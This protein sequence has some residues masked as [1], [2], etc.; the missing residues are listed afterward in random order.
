MSD[1]Q[2]LE[3]KQEH[4]SRILS[5]LQDPGKFLITKSEVI[6]LILREEN[7]FF[8]KLMREGNG[9]FHFFHGQY[10]YCFR[11]LEDALAYCLK[12]RQRMMERPLI[13]VYNSV[14]PLEYLCLVR[15][16][17]ER[18]ILSPEILPRQLLRI[19]QFH[20]GLF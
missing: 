9:R 8:V 17:K 18:M 4:R 12:E 20:N 14:P 2:Y 16:A 7:G 15:V 10:M 19:L 1:S 3:L 11:Q 6:C 13:P 5:Y